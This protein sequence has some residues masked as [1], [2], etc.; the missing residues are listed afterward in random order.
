M[1]RFEI[2]DHTADVKI[3]AY[4]LTLE[5]LFESAAV[6]FFTV[7]ADLDG[8]G[9]DVSH[10]I[11]A[12]AASLQELMVSW[13]NELLYHYE[14][15]RL[16]LKRFKVSTLSERSLSATGY[17]ERLEPSRHTIHR[18]VKMVTYHQLKVGRD[19]GGFFAEVILDL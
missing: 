10:P 2:L 6:A 8:V 3:R 11:S 4:G 19:G 7:I 16:L 17:G 12:E 14:V 18:E 15:K 13:L 1:A 5:E 9:E